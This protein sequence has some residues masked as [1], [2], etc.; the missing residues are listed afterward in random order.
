MTDRD[1]LE[2]NKFHLLKSDYGRKSDLGIRIFLAV[3]LV[4][5]CVGVLFLGD[6]SRDSFLE[7]LPLI[8]LLIVLEASYT[9]LTEVWLKY[10]IG[11]LKKKGKMAF[12]SSSVLEFS[13]DA[14]VETTETEKTEQ[15]Y[16]AVEKIYINGGKIIYIFVNNIRAYLIPVSTFENEKQYND[17]L[18]FLKEKTSLEIK[19][20]K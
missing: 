16:S 20:V 10:Y 4:A 18:Q 17:F 19:E 3:F 14:I 12:S 8:I 1:Y 5:V 13:E 7:I 11:K 9:K 15:K 2:F 6:F